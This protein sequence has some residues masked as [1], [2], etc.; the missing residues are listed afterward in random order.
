MSDKS[1]KSLV[2]YSKLIALLQNRSTIEHSTLSVWSDSPFTGIV[3]GE[4]FFLNDFR[5]RIREEL[6]FD[7][8][9]ITSYGYE[10]YHGKERLC[11]YDDFPHPNDDEY[12]LRFLIINTFLQT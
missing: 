6:D 2:E 12:L 1:L 8:G 9:L 5:L 11:W 3:E 4:I 7:A 10:I